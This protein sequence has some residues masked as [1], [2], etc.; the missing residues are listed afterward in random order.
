MAIFGFTL[1]LSALLLFLAELMF[2][3]IVLPLLGGTPAVW[4]TCMVFFQAALLAGYAYAHWLTSRVTT[5]RQTLIHTA[6]MLAPT[7]LLPIGVPQ[8]WVPPAEGNPVPWLLA[9]MLVTVGPPFVAVSTTAPVLQRWFART[10]HPA[11]NDPYF[12]YAASNAGSLMSLAG[13]LIVIEPHLTIAEQARVWAYGYVLLALLVGACAWIML[14]SPNADSVTDD[15]L[16][17][18]PSRVR[19]PIPLGRRVRWLGLA[20]MPSSLML[21]FT[22]Y[23]TTDIASVPLLWSIPLAI[24]L[25]TF[26]LAF[27]RRSLLH[28][29]L[30]VRALP[31]LVLIQTIMLPAAHLPFA[32]AIPIHLLT[33]F[34]TALLCHRE[35]ADD[36]PPVEHLTMFYL[37]VATGGVLGG[38]FN[39]ILAPMVF[40]SV[41]E[42]PLILVLTCVLCLKPSV[43][44]QS[45]QPAYSS[46]RA[47][48]IYDILLPA[49]IAGLTL[50]LNWTALALNLDRSPQLMAS[51]MGLVVLACY[52]LADRPVRFGLALAAVLIVGINP[53]GMGLLMHQER[54]FFGVIRVVG[55]AGGALHKLYSGTT[56][57]GSQWTSSA[58]YDSPTSYYSPIGPLG[59]VMHVANTQSPQMKVGTIGLGVGGVCAYAKAGQ[60]FTFYEIDPAVERVAEN[61]GYFTYLARARKRGADVRVVLGDGRLAMSKSPDGAYDLII[62]DAF[63]SDSIPVHLL[64]R[65]ALQLYIRKLRE[66]GIITVNVSSRHLDLEPLVSALAADAGLVAFIRRDTRV[67]R[68]EIDL[69]RTPSVWA[70]FA[71]D[72]ADLGNLPLRPGWHRAK[73]RPGMRVWT[74]DYSNILQVLDIG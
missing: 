32:K 38:M 27:S 55:D 40:R 50:A 56:L 74:D 61:T 6:L 30:L 53:G 12:L 59:Q 13:Y 31:M 17:I 45:R 35:L 4:N 11:A 43:A 63:S 7:L 52:P 46:R 66:H 2:A 9:L 57:H 26:I 44:T 8:R 54:N 69:G 16:Q 70:V 1:F 15:T 37:I 10:S 64:T 47:Y 14:R 39:G 21:G 48:G 20:F 72:E 29:E 68:R 36:R 60:S 3:K 22:T 25:A 49:C 28:K 73:A 34:V 62:L 65:E 41:L 5:R 33:F 19:S 18:G 42:Y 23:A 24:Y 58:L 67:V 71:R 51:I